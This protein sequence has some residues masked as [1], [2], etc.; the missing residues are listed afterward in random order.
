MKQLLSKN[1]KAKSEGITENKPKI[2]RKELEKRHKI[3]TE[4][5]KR[6]KKP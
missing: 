2:T 3:D 5:F 6:E 4:V 1:V